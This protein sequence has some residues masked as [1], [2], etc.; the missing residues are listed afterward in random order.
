MCNIL[1]LQRR[2]PIFVCRLIHSMYCV[3]LDDDDCVC[4]IFCTNDAWI[5]SPRGWKHCLLKCPLR[6]KNNLE[7]RCEDGVVLPSGV[8]AV[9]GL[10]RP[11]SGR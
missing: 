5:I 8:G 3:L 2:P 9:F 11:R 4:C 1:W 6:D 10:I 7:R